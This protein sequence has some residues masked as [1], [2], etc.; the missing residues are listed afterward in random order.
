MIVGKA[1]EN[2]K[3]HAFNQMLMML[4]AKPTLK[5]LMTNDMMHDISSDMKKENT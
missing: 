4:L 3:A 2:A 5:T 1:T